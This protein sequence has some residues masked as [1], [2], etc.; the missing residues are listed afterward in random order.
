MQLKRQETPVLQP[1]L[2]YAYFL[3]IPGF[4]LTYKIN[5]KFL[6]RRLIFYDTPSGQIK[7]CSIFLSDYGNSVVAA[8]PGLLS[9]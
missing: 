7:E 3:L 2:I 6:E 8:M 1:V 9:G 5:D 4:N